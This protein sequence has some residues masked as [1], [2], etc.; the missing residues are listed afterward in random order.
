MHVNINLVIEPHNPYCVFYR[1]QITVCPM[2]DERIIVFVVFWY[3][4][5]WWLTI[6]P[7]EWSSFPT[8][9]PKT[10]FSCRLGFII[11]SMITVRASC[12]FGSIHRVENF[13][14]PLQY[15]YLL[16]D[17]LWSTV[18]TDKS[19]KRWSKSKEGRKYKSDVVSQT[20]C[21]RLVHI[22]WNRYAILLCIVGLVFWDGKNYLVQC[23]M[24]TQ[25]ENVNWYWKL[26]IA[27]LLTHP[28]QGC[29]F[30]VMSHYWL[31]IYMRYCDSGT[32]T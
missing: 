12:H 3:A 7:L 24:N 26:K 21:A 9:I 23:L 31:V 5:R 6:S 13:T 18:N 2:P 11:Y 32:A 19:K 14:Y 4:P 29:L 15:K 28:S 30:Y 17:M 22:S 10:Q 8:P 20:A 1:D 25:P 16:D 27:S